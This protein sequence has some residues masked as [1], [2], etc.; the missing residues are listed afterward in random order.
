MNGKKIKQPKSSIKNKNLFPKNVNLGEGHILCKICGDKA[1]GFHYGVFSCEGCK[2]FFRRTIR[3]QLT[4]KPCDTPSQ[5]LI[6]RISRNRCQYCRLQKCISLGMSHEA[7]RL[8]RCPKKSRPSSNSFFRLPQ[9]QQ[10]HVDLDRQLKT[11]QMVLYVHEAYKYS[12]K[13][14]E[15][16]QPFS[17]RCDEILRCDHT[18]FPT[19][20][21]TQ[22]VPSIVMFITTLAKKIPQFLDV[23]QEDQRALIKGSILEIA[24]LYDATHVKLIQ[25]WWTNTKLKFSISRSH[26]EQMSFIGKIIEKFWSLMEKVHKMALT[27][28]EMSLICALLIFS[29]DREGLTTIR[30]LENLETE[31]A[32]ALKCQLILNHSDLPYIFVHLI[33]IIIELRGVSALYLEAVLES[34]VDKS[35]PSLSNIYAETEEE[36]ET[37]F[38]SQFFVQANLIRT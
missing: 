32:M 1:S 3:H 31:L 9:T 15:E 22:Y 36:T 18:N 34:K 27:D 16:C 8:G 23:S 25:D 14:F 7:V 4:Y 24:F 2:G 26:L 13:L 17:N 29:P 11:E 19:I 35:T 5:C 20:F 30:Y 33:D 38:K 21:F 10:G 6:M 28:V 37:A 12:I